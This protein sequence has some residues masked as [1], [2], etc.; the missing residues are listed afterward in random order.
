MRFIADFHIHSRYSRATSQE[1]TVEKIAQAARRKGVKLVGTGDFTHPKWLKELEDKLKP[2]GEGLFECD[3]I[4]FI[5]VT[6]VNNTYTQNGRLR[7]IHN[8]I[9]APDFQSVH[10]INEKLKSYGN[11]IVDGRPTLVLDSKKLIELMCGIGED[12]WVVP[13]HVWTPWFSLFGSNSGFDSIEEC[14]ADYTSRIIAL[15]TGLSSDPAMNWRLSSLDRFTLISNSDAHSP[16]RIGREANCFDCKLS[17]YDVMDAIR[18]KDRKRFL[19]TIEFFPQEGKYHYD[20][21]RRCGVRVPP[22]EAMANNDLCPVCSKRLTIGVLH[23]IETL[24]DREEGFVPP[25]AIPFKSLIPLDEI[26]ADALGVGVDTL[27]VRNE[28]QNLI[29]KFNTEFAILLDISIDALRE[30][31]VPEVAEGIERVRESKVVITPGYDGVYG[32]VKI[33]DREE[34]QPSQLNLF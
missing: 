14:F 12:I 25:D 7:R 16:S 33:F 15:E 13:A 29:N 24:S 10:Q 17:Y 1:M 32:E 5:L 6:E 20:G 3:D 31:T 22:R 34:K 19:F 30:V 28:Y 4:C 2:K 8:M 21:H 11:L 18:N 23:R 9:F 26:I 27:T